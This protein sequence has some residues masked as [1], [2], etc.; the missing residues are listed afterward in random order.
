[1]KNAFFPIALLFSAGLGTVTYLKREAIKEHMPR[2]R[3]GKGQ[4]GYIHGETG[5]AIDASVAAFSS[6]SY[7]MMSR[8]DLDTETHK[9]YS[10]YLYRCSSEA[11]MP[12]KPSEW[13]DNGAPLWEE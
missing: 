9:D 1:M 12:L 4:A 7:I 5:S 6:Q 3:P 10:R 11:I 8:G 13:L 2:L